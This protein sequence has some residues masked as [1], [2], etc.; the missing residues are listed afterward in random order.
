MTHITDA[1][2]WAALTTVR[3]IPGE[4]WKLWL[5]LDRHPGSSVILA[6]HDYQDAAVRVTYITL[7]RLADFSGLNDVDLPTS[8]AEWAVCLWGEYV[9]QAEYAASALRGLKDV[10]E[11]HGMVWHPVNYAG[12]QIKAA[13]GAAGGALATV[14]LWLWLLLLILGLF[15]L[16]GTRHD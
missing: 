11:S 1:S 12:E 2:I 8:T 10:A 3:A 5:E 13:A 7:E 4:T 15:Y 9:D 16:W 6:L 14:G